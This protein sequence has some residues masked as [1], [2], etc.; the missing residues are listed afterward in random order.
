M[1]KLPLL[2]TVAISIFALGACDLD[3][4]IRLSEDDGPRAP[5]RAVTQLECPDHQGPLTRIRTTPDGL[6]CV[7]AGP[8]GAEVTLRL[9]K[10]EGGDAS[11]M[12]SALERDLNRLL[13]QVAEKIARGRAEEERAAAEERRADA[14]T[15]RREAEAEKAEA[16]VERAE[17]EVERAQALAEKARAEAEG[18]RAE[19]ARAQA[20]ADRI[21]RRLAERLSRPATARDE[22]D[23]V[24]VSGPGMRIRSE[25]DR[26]D[27]SLPGISIR[28]DGERA[29]VQ[30]GP[31]KIKADDA[32]GDVNISDDDTEMS[33]R[34]EDDAAEI[35][36]R[37]RGPEGGPLV[38]AVVKAKDRR[39]DDV[40]DA[41]KA[42]VKRNAGG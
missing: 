21:A 39:E 40:F 3:R 24:N 27:V 13:P 6:S 35:R 7:Y 10:L 9:V 18:D 30:V 20:R 34:G 42:L 29:D 16:A 31:I 33:V 25:G 38:V 8:K 28:A 23:R 22:G 12:L 32:S 19:A 2:A 26:A 15:Q 11:A 37:R 4:K 36:T 41:A 5:F 14:E 1:P 17:L